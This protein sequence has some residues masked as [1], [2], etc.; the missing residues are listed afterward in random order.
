MG[1]SGRARRLA[2][3]RDRHVAA[4]EEGETAETRAG[5]IGEV[6]AAEGLLTPQKGKTEE[7]R[8]RKEGSEI[9]QEVREKQ[10]LLLRIGHEED[11]IEGDLLGEAV[12][13]SQQGSEEQE[14][15]LRQ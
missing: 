10:E 7:H 5:Q 8:A 14:A 3:G 15:D 2:A 9:E 11:R 13:R 4:D 6:D 1:R 12:R